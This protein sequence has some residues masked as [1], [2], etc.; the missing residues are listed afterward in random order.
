MPR[1]D[2]RGIGEN[3]RG[4]I[5]LIARIWFRGV[6]Y[7]RTLRGRQPRSLTMIPEENWPGSSDR[8]AELV[9]GRFRFLNHSISAENLAAGKSDA[10]PAWQAEYHSF[11]WLRDIRAVG[12]EAAR[13][14][15]RTY[16]IDWIA[17]NQKWHPVSWRPDVLARRLSNWLTHA[18]FVSAGTEEDFAEPFLGSI[19]RQARHLRRA[20]RFVPNGLDRI[21]VTKAL[22]YLSLCL[23]NSIRFL[24]RQLKSV[25]RISTQQI[26][27]DGGH[28]ERSPVAQMQAMRHLIDIRSVLNLSL[29]DIPEALH[30][31]IERAAPMLRLFRHGDG[32]LALFNGSTEGEPWLIDVVLSKSEVSQRP[33][34]SAPNTGFERIA[35]KRTLVISDSGAPSTVG[36]GAHAGV[37]SFEMSVGK[38]RVIVNC[39]A[40]V[41]RDKTWLTAQRATAAHSTLVVEDRNSAEIHGDG[42]IDAKGISVTRERLEGGSNTWID[43]SHDGYTAAFDIVHRRRIYVDA[44]GSD[45]RG[46]D[47]LDGSGDHKFSI[48]FHLHPAIKASLL[49]DGASVLLRLPDKSGW[50]MRCSG[51]IATL[52]ESI[53][54]GDG[55]DTKRTEQIVIAGASK[56]GSAKVKWALTKFGGK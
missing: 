12:T 51:G 27:P 37:L 47:R 13:I 44:S 56:Q 6:F 54:L 9:D 20:G 43:M 18:E 31:A 30:R 38:Q 49:K 34:T 2:Q 42:T 46:E 17:A 33:I 52:Q 50:R 15:A 19:A 48:R 3:L 39:G 26:L 10:G 29:I 35:A 21:L 36:V 40:Y 4:A 55:Q 24:P 14:Q 1:L 41:G 16:L 45:I 53:Y 28:I 5:Y 22:I 8:G 23:P 11:D 7:G 32:G 25:A